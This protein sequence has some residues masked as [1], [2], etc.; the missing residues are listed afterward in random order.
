MTEDKEDEGEYDE[1]DKEEDNEDEETGD[2]Q[3]G[4]DDNSGTV[5]NPFHPW[6]FDEFEEQLN[7]HWNRGIYHPGIDALT[8]IAE[9]YEERQAALANAANIDLGLSE[10]LLQLTQELEGLDTA[11]ESNKIIAQSI[12][13][14]LFNLLQGFE[15][16][17]ALDFYET[18]AALNHIE[19]SEFPEDEPVEYGDS[20]PPRP[21]EAFEEGTLDLIAQSII[22][23]EEYPSELKEPAYSLID[24][25]SLIEKRHAYTELYEAADDKAH[26]ILEVTTRAATWTEIRIYVVWLYLCVKTA[27]NPQNDTE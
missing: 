26:N 13:P 25:S 17:A 2:E 9:D 8:K 4:E 7:N 20:E 6:P 21:A 19:I 12:N 5:S 27:L 23:N 22:E 14:D 11:I 1:S 16:S 3:E 10:A 15:S 24:T 18:V